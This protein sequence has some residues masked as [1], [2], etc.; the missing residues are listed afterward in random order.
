VYLAND[1]ID[2]LEMEGALIDRQLIEE[3]NYRSPPEIIAILGKLTAFKRQDTK[4]CL[5]SLRS[6]GI[7]LGVDFSTFDDADLREEYAQILEF[8]FNYYSKNRKRIDEESPKVLLQGLGFGECH[9]DRRAS[10]NSWLCVKTDRDV[11]CPVPQF[12]SEAGRCYYV[13]FVT[14]KKT[15]ENLLNEIDLEATHSGACIVFCKGQYSESERRRLAHACQDR[16]KTVLLVDDLLM[17]G[18]ATGLNNKIETF[19]RATLPYTY[20]MPYSTT[21][22]LLPKEM[23]YGRSR[24][25]E[26]LLSDGTDAAFFLYGGRQIGKTV[27]LRHVE[28]QFHNPD[29]GRLAKYLALN[30]KGLGLTKQVEEIWAV[31]AD[32]LKH[33]YPD[34]FTATIPRQVEF[35]WFEKQ[36][37]SWLS[38]D[39]NRRVLLLLDEADD[40]LNADGQREGFAP[41]SQCT[42]LKALMENTQRR[43][44]VVFAGLHNVQRSTRVGNNPLA[45]FGTPICIGPMLRHGEAR[46]AMNLVRRPMGSLGVFFEN[47]DYINSILARTNYYPNLIQIYCQNLLKKVT[48]QQGYQFPDRTPPYFISA[49]DVDSIYESEDLRGELREKFRLTLDLDRR[50]SLIAHLLALYSTDY[51]EG[52]TVSEIRESSLDSWRD[53]FK[54]GEEAGQF[55]SYEGFRNILEEMEGLGILRKSGADRFGL[56]SPNVAALLGTEEAIWSVLESAKSWK[57]D[58]VYESEVFRSLLDAENKLSRSVF[59]AVQEGQ[60]KT[61][62]RTLTIVSGHGLSGVE[63]IHEALSH[64]LGEAYVLKANPIKTAGEFSEEL[65]RLVNR[66]ESGKSVMLVTAE[67]PWGMDWL[68]TA[69]QRLRPYSKDS[70]PVGVVFIADG[71]KVDCLI[72]DM[73]RAE[74]LGATFLTLEPW[75]DI[76]IRQWLE[77]SHLGRQDEMV[78]RGIYSATGN[79]H[80]GLMRFAQGVEGASNILDVLKQIES[81]L[82]STAFHEDHWKKLQL[83]NELAEKMFRLLAELLEKPS[84]VAEI[85][86]FLESEIP[87]QQQ[88]RHLMRWA[89]AVGLA[90]EGPDG[91]VLDG[92][93]S[94]ILKASNED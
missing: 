11:P 70:A 53:G 48:E 89:S 18:M 25:V 20:L 31:L 80:V 32:E 33:L 63:Y 47:S 60:I 3:S 39:S 87:D 61:G 10:I 75:N 84:P 62:N 58:P 29:R 35:R 27:L 8:W 36:I 66:P 68:D 93:A 2:R 12:G 23:F 90:T 59:T 56:R 54:S 51:P 49:K 21:A 69:A 24:E 15:P 44:K 83:P 76:A 94:R 64:C 34:I 22:S 19:F 74:K 13:Q 88:V 14:S 79:W 82:S 41:F 86:D 73:G 26:A 42:C 4:L 1:Y 57:P 40:F 37:T 55:L 7:F 9:V 46:A 65:K 71:A 5:S 77:D 17:I 81:E 91:W 30:V 92:F 16:K 45:H 6:G 78:R 28:Q 72:D 50:F 38:D 67:H 43:F 52:V 85:E